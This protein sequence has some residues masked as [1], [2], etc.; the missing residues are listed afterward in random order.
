MCELDI[1]VYIITSMFTA[2]AWQG[3]N[4]GMAGISFS[5]ILNVMFTRL[6]CSF[7]HCETE[8]Q[9]IHGVYVC[10]HVCMRVCIVYVCLLVRMRVCMC[11]DMHVCMYVCVYVYVHVRVIMYVLK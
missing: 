11:V 6:S 10:L 4:K 8:R 7:L 1:K 3:C 2:G 9:E 5:Y